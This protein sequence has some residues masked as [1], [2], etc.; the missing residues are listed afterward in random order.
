MREVWSNIHK[1]F[2]QAKG[3]TTPLNR[4]GLEQ[5]STLRGDLYRWWTM[6]G[7]AIPILVQLARIAD[8]IPESQDIEVAV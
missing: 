5:T 3:H 1:W 6:E 8:D 2:Q 7:E 4:E